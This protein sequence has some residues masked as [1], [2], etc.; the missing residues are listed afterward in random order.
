M[1]TKQTK[2]VA[3]ISDLRSEK[4]FLRELYE[5]GVDV[6]RLNTAHQAIEATADV[7]KVIRSISDDIGILIDTKGPEVRTGKVAEPVPVETGERIDIVPADKEYSGKEKV[8]RVSYSKFTEEIERRS[9]VLIDDGEVSLMVQGKSSAA[10]ECIAE[11]NGEIGSRKGVNVPGSKLRLPSL[12]EKDRGYIR[13]AMEENINFIAHS[14]VRNVDDVLAIKELLEDKNDI[15]KI[16]AKIENQEGVDNLSEILGEAYGL[17]VA[18]GDLAMEIPLWDVPVIQKRIISECIRKA[19]PVITATQMLYTMI[20][21]PRPTRAEINDVANAVFDGSDAVMLSGETA[22]G[23]YPVEAVQMMSKII[24]SV[25]AKKPSFKKE[26]PTVW[27]NP[28]QRFLAESAYDAALKLPVK[29]IVTMTRWGATARLLSSFRPRVPI[30]TLCTK[31]HTKRILALQYGV[32]PSFVQ[33]KDDHSES[34]YETMSQLLHRR[35]LQED[36]L[37]LI[38]GTDTKTSYA[39]DLIEIKTVRSLIYEKRKQFD[40]SRLF[41]EQE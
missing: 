31:E 21:H 18:R 6:F 1:V 9:R 32:Y 39:A 27:Q 4:A 15:I 38:I 26:R 16:I 41:L 13:L 19:Q 7:L 22:I 30:Y 3:T 40:Y 37:V 5:S 11:N 2:I 35:K 12:T 17:M 25:E 36:D 33:Q 20:N 23:K 28:V 34:I 24:Q 10:L 14:F 29:A 8:I